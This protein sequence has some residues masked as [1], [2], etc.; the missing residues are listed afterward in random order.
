MQ[1]VP[2]ETAPAPAAASVAPRRNYTYAPAK[3]GM[4]A[5]MWDAEQRKNAWLK[6][7]FIGG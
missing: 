6:R 2:M 5:R 4:L 1:T 7:T 3:K